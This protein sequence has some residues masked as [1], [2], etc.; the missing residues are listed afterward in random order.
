MMLMLSE[1][2]FVHLLLEMGCGWGLVG[3]EK[4]GGMTGM[5]SHIMLS[6]GIKM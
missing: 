4:G 1:I 6:S 2:H 5:F 3:E